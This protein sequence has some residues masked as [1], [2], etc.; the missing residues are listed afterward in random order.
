MAITQ[1][2]HL[3]MAR[4]VEKALEIEPALAE[5]AAASACVV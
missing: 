2:L 3:E 1:D 4:V 5:A